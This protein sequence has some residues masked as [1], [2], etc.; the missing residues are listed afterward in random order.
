MKNAFERAAK[1]AAIDRAK[2]AKL[3]TDFE[4]TTLRA[5]AEKRTILVMKNELSSKNICLD[6]LALELQS[7][8]Q[9]NEHG[10]VKLQDITKEYMN[11]TRISENQK[12]MIQQLIIER[13]HLIEENHQHKKKI[14]GLTSK[15]E[16][17]KDNHALLGNELS[18]K[19][20][21]IMELDRKYA[22]LY[23]KLNEAKINDDQ[24]HGLKCKFEHCKN[25]KKQMEETNL[26]LRLELKEQTDCLDRNKVRLEREI[27]NLK[28]ELVQLRSQH[29]LRERELECRQR[30]EH[31]GLTEKLKCLQIEKNE[32]HKACSRSQQEAQHTTEA[33]V[34]ESKCHFHHFCLY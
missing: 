15:L 33:L 23:N 20:K 25:K 22:T 14:H 4:N 24:L 26:Q 29:Q 12:D 18:L 19:N 2:F 30:M 13:D 3:E 34:K 6:K 5:E 10:K 8:K 31:Y 17:S 16:E 27:I 1:R 7:I 32:L 21:L 11:T 9:N 28:N